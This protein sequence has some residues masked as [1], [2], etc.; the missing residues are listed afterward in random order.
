[1]V[2]GS[3]AEMSMPASFITSFARGYQGAA[4]G[5]RTRYIKLVAREI[6]QKTLGDQAARGVASREK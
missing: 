1:M 4:F 6:A 5:R 3:S 2:F